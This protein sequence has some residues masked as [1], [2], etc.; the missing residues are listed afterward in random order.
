MKHSIKCILSPENVMTLSWG[1]VKFKLD[2]KDFSFPFI[3]CRKCL[4]HIVKI[5]AKER[6]K[7]PT[8]ECVVLSYAFKIVDCLTG[9]ELKSKSEV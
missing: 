5:Y 8:E 1:T 7:W 9:R 3:M 2:K 6:K 4:S